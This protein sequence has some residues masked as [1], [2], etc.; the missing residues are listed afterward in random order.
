MNLTKISQGIEKVDPKRK[1]LHKP[2][3]GRG[4]IL[5]PFGTLNCLIICHKK[6][7]Y[8]NKYRWKIKSMN[9]LK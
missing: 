8:G 2:R 3:K 1:K 4:G 5:S 6:D 7:S 9:V